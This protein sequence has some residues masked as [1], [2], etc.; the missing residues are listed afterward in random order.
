MSWKLWKRLQHFKNII[1]NWYNKIKKGVQEVVACIHLQFWHLLVVPWWRSVGS[2][3]KSNALARSSLEK[4]WSIFRK[5]FV[6]FVTSGFNW[7]YTSQF[8]MEDPVYFNIFGFYKNFL[9]FCLFPI[10]KRDHF[11]KRD[12]LNLKNFKCQIWSPIIFLCK[13]KPMQK[14]WGIPWWGVK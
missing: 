6:N 8:E 13:N 2:I 7:M 11:R 1:T 5:Y 14:Q 10:H 4:S 9:E 12:F 3:M